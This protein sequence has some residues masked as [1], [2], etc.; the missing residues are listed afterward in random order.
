M[1]SGRTG[2]RCRVLG[3]AIL[4]MRWRKKALYC[5]T[6]PSEG[7]HGKHNSFALYFALFAGKRGRAAQRK[8]ARAKRTR[9]LAFAK[10]F[11]AFVLGARAIEG[12][13][14]AEHSAQASTASLLLASTC[15]AMRQNSSANAGFTRRW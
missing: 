3:C 2:G 10:K 1:V 8:E 7:A 11:L 15:G 4:M 14:L 12:E 13:R 5:C 9:I 6:M